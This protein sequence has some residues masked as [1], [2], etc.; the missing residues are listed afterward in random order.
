MKR[1]IRRHWRTQRNMFDIERKFTGEIVNGEAT[2]YYEKSFRF[3]GGE[4]EV[5]L[6][7]REAHSASHPFCLDL[8]CPCHYEDQTTIRLLAQ[9]VQDGAFTEA[10]AKAIF[11]GQR[12][13][14][15]PETTVYQ[16]QRRG[17]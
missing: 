8:F 14:D 10:E 13:L 1:N 15:T 16:Q 9:L 17:A 12:P 7:D 4:K 11:H 5:L 2:Y 6:E 3:P